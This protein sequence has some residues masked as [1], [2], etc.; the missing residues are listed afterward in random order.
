MVKSMPPLELRNLI[1]SKKKNWGQFEFWSNKQESHSPASLVDLRITFDDLHIAVDLND[2]SCCQAYL[3][4]GGCKM[5]INGVAAIE[6]KTPTLRNT[7]YIVCTNGEWYT[8]VGVPPKRG[9][10]EPYK[11]AQRARYRIQEVVLPVR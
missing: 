1:Q 7:F 10:P 9:G 4:G 11:E 6:Y 3:S 2:R 5:Y 8:V